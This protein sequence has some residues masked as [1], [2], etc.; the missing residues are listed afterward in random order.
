MKWLDWTNSSWRRR[1]FLLATTVL[2]IGVASNPELAA[3]VPVL[4]AL[5][6]D[7]L[8][9]LMGTRLILAFKDL[10][11]PFA[12]DACRRWIRSAIGYASC[13]LGLFIGGYC[14]QLA[15][16]IRHAGIHGTVFWPGNPLQSALLRESAGS[17]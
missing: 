3:L 8:L 4:D 10:S 6:L 2:I 9:Y 5:G 7:V 16:H 1:A 14:R 13:P 15:W 12:R 17:R 11:A